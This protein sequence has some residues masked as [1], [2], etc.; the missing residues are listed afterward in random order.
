MK[1]ASMMM[2]GTAFLRSTIVV[3]LKQLF[4]CGTADPRID[5]SSIIS[6]PAA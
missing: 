4:V 3:V 1:A 5:G 2:D 6:A